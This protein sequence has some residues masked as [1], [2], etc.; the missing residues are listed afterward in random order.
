MIFGNR[1]I[2]QSLL[3]LEALHMRNK[4]P[5]LNK[6]NFETS[7]NVFNIFSDSFHT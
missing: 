1:S 7:A 3:I 4:R 6:I 2:K 5:N